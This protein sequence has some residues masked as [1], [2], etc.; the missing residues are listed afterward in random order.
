MI[1]RILLPVVAAS[2]LAFCG[3]AANAKRFHSVDMTD[4]E[5]KAYCKA[6]PD[7]C[8]TTIDWGMSAV[9]TIGGTLFASALGSAFNSSDE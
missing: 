4:E 1:K 5:T 8:E 9:L 3:T 6:N 2:A 7:N